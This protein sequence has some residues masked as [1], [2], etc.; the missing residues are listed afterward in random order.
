MR[1]L[2]FS[3]F[4]IGLLIYSKIPA[5]SQE[6]L[7]IRI[8][9]NGNSIENAT[10]GDDGRRVNQFQ[11]LPNPYDGFYPM[12][13]Y[14]PPP[15]PPPFGPPGFGHPHHHFGSFPPP[16][17][18]PI[19]HCNC[20][21]TTAQEGANEDRNTNTNGTFTELPVNGTSGN[22][23]TEWGSELYPLREGAPA[24][25]EVARFQNA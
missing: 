16:P 3:P 25:P 9:R 13:F 18:R 24:D 10:D 6:S 22:N 2:I 15:P 11:H 5:S 17:P 21:R 4:F 7:L 12:P 23:G 20:N 1:S 14:P 19:N 8:A